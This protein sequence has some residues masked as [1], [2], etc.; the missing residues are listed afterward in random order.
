M[1][2]ILFSTLFLIPPTTP[3]DSSAKCYNTHYS[4]GHYFLE[5][6]DT[7]NARHHLEVASSFELDHSTGFLSTLF[8]LYKLSEETRC[9]DSILVELMKR[10]VSKEYIHRL[11]GSKDN[12]N[13]YQAIINFDSMSIN[14]PRINIEFLTKLKELFYADQVIRHYSSEYPQAIRKIDSVNFL[15]LMN[16][17]QQ[18]GLPSYTNVGFEGINCVIALFLHQIF[19]GDYES[20]TIFSLAESLYEQGTFDAKL[21]AMII[22]RHAVVSPQKQTGSKG[23]Q[24]YGSISRFSENIDYQELDQRRLNIGLLPYIL[25]SKDQSF[26]NSYIPYSLDMVYISLDSCTK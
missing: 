5:K 6:K 15:N 19:L 13:E 16:I 20:S 17:I 18:Y 11:I 10:N 12:S 1:I 14:T 23:N 26:P 7:L 25:T 4:L 8:N 22:D 9:S 2:L 21:Y 3:A 24:V